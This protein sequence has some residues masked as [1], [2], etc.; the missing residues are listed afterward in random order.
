[1]VPD[2]PKSSK[3]GFA[4]MTPEQV[5]AI[6]SRGGKS[7][8]QQ[9]KAYQ[10]NKEQAALAGSKGGKAPRRSRTMDTEEVQPLDKS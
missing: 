1:M 3:R 9:G 8:H 6:A 10:W 7:A 4:S 5:R 2:A